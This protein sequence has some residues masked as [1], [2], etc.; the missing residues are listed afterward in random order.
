MS[1]YCCGGRAERMRRNCLSFFQGFDVLTNRLLA[2]GTFKRH[3]IGHLAEAIDLEFG[4]RADH[5]N[6]TARV[7]HG[8]FGLVRCNPERLGID[9]GAAR[10]L[11]LDAQ[12]RLHRHLDVVAVIVRNL[13]PN[14]IGLI[15][16]EAAPRARCANAERAADIRRWLFITEHRQLQLRHARVEQATDAERTRLRTL[17]EFRDLGVIPLERNLPVL[18]H[19]RPWW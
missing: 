15:H 17:L 9:L 11:R 18:G 8:N 19:R 1:G 2:L 6:F 10:Q 3:R 16:G 13:V 7:E 14:R 5:A 12:V 4:D